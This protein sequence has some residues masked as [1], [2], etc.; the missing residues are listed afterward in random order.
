MTEEQQELYDIVS[1]WWD[2][3]FC[4]NPAPVDRDGEYL[5]KN[6][7]IIDLVNAIID[8]KD[9]PQQH[10][11][12][13]W[14]VV[15]HQLGFSIDMCDEIVGA[16]EEWLP[17]EHDTNSYEWNKCVRMMREKLWEQSE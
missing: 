13:L 4:N 9:P 14:N 15:R 8:W 10:P 2:E 16:V 6:P 11:P 1:D 5:D 3:V 17:K 12:S 7:T